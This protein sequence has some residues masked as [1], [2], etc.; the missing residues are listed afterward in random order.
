MY[1]SEISENVISS[2][3]QINFVKGVKKVLPPPLV[4]FYRNVSI[5]VDRKGGKDFGAPCP[6]TRSLWNCL[7]EFL[8]PPS[9]AATESVRAV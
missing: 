8:L 7:L 4:D 2:Q 5:C 6:V 1:F 3:H 9:G